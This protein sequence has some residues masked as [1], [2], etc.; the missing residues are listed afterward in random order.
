KIRAVVGVLPVLPCPFGQALAIRNEGEFASRKSDIPQRAVRTECRT[1]GDG[2]KRGAL[3]AIGNHDVILFGPPYG[4]SDV[5]SV[6]G[7]GGRRHTVPAAFQT[8]NAGRKNQ[9]CSFQESLDHRLG[10]GL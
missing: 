8:A 3:S 1:A 4:I 9:V 5:L 10:S 2:L 6:R 7:C